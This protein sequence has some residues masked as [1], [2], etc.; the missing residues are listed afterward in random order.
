VESTAV[1]FG[2]LVGTSCP[3]WVTPVVANVEGEVLQPVEP[4]K[5][6]KEVDDEHSR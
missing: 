1:T 6:R 3:A 5:H 2:E 4:A